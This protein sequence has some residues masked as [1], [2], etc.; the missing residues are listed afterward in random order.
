MIRKS[1]CFFLLSFTLV[2]GQ[3]QTFYLPVP[4]NWQVETMSIP[5]EFAPQIPYTGEEHLRFAPGWGDTKSEELWSYCFLWW[6]NADAKVSKESLER[7]L[8]AYYSGLV[9]RNLVRRKIDSSLVVPTRANF[10]EENAAGGG[11]KSFSGTVS[12][13][14]YLSLRPVILQLR[15]TAMPCTKEKKLAIFIAVSPQPSAHRIWQQFKLVLKG[16]RCAK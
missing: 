2:Y 4:A 13:L 6:I 14:D 5:I 15:V 1:L 8:Q 3:A 12:M 7:D 10:R 11:S 16:F 9:G